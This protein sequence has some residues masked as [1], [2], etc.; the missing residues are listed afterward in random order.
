MQKKY[1]FIVIGG[2]SSGCVVAARLSENKNIRVL[3]LEAGKKD[4]NWK[5]KVPAAFFKT[6][7]T[8]LDWDYET[9]AQPFLN[10]RKLYVPRGKVLG[11]S[12]SI[13]AMIYIRG[14]KEDYN[15]WA[16]EGNTNW[17]YEK[18]LPFFKKAENNKDLNGENIGKNGPLQVCNLSDPNELTYKYLEAA[19]ANGLKNV[20]NFNTGCEQE[21][22]GIFQ[23]T[24][25]NGVRSSPSKA[26]LQ[27]IKNR[28]NLTILTGA[29][30]L[31]ILIENK[32]AVGV[33]VALK[34]GIQEFFAEK[35]IVLSAGAFNSP[36]ILMLSGIGGG[37]TL[38]NLG[39]ECIH[40]L[41]AVGQHLQDHP[42]VPLIYRCNKNITL[43]TAENLSNFLK[44]IFYRKG[45]LTSILAEGGGYWRTDKN[46]AAPDIQY[47]FG[48]VFFVNHGFTRPPGNGFSLG[49][50]LVKPKSRGNVALK[51]SDPDE[52]P[53]INPNIF[54]DET[55]LE[56]LTAGFSLS[57]KIMNAEPLKP[58]KQAYFMPEKELTDIDE[59]KEYI[60]AN[61]EALY[62]PVGSCRMGTEETGVTNQELKVYGIENL[63]VVDASVMPSVTR[64]NTNAPSIM[65][66]EKGADIIKKQWKIQ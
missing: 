5:L 18:V 38:K 8:S 4:T 41:P 59:I 33:K 23:C 14:H 56:K 21:C 15:E 36:Q 53:L 35:E 40:D 9:I 52:K 29:K 19:Q 12:G 54:A 24:Q 27:P 50:I 63:R 39:I 28:E 62:H 13:N 42:V 49:T 7:K 57:Q 16:A 22:S 2:G 30:V 48:P 34:N 25:L 17:S 43:D 61:T 1:D 26:Y 3:L 58:Y 20:D 45:A 65:I 60:K 6:F 64:G 32:K 55:D 46:L 51:S 66:G 47:H 10:N 37:N 44:Y 31:K 11:G